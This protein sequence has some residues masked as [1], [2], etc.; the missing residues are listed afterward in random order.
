VFSSARAEENTGRTIREE[1]QRNSG[2]IQVQIE[3]RTAGYLMWGERTIEIV[4][5]QQE[6]SRKPTVKRGTADRNQRDGREK[7]EREEEVKH[8]ILLL[9]TIVQTC[10]NTLMML[11]RDKVLL[12]ILSFW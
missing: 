6:L 4:P 5:V 9:K 3:D 7:E 8:E 2:E 11:W 10:E 1:E 12:C